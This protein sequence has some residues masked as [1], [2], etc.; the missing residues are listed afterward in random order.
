M[1]LIINLRIDDVE[2]IF[3]VLFALYIVECCWWL[4]GE[5]QR[6]YT[7]PANRWSSLPSEKPLS[8]SWRLTGA[9]PLPGGLSFV[10]EQF[11]CP[12]D[13]HYLLIPKVDSNTGCE[14]YKAHEYESLLPIET[15]N[16]SVIS[17]D[18]LIG[19]F[20]SHALAN[21]VAKT[22]ECLRVAES[23][24]RQEIAAE[25]LADRWSYSNA[26]QRLINWRKR[27][28]MLRYFG[29]VLTV[30]GFIVGPVV[31]ESRGLLPIWLPRGVFISFLFT[32]ISTAI[33]GLWLTAEQSVSAP[34]NL[35][36]RLIPFLSPVSAMRVA[37]TSGRDV[38][39]DFEPL[40]VAF[41]TRD[42][43]GSESVLAA[44]L[45]D[46]VYPAQ[47]LN[48][49]PDNKVDETLQAYR[50]QCKK[51]TSRVIRA[52]DC[53]SEHLLRAPFSENDA[54]AYCPRC[55]RTFREHMINCFYCGVGVQPTKH[56]D[57]ER[58]G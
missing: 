20:S 11:P 26:R 58:V 16:L 31:Y 7:W 57:S 13:E 6:F 10:A 14:F 47:I 24:K 17:G 2:Q 38:L 23:E 4:R 1:L 3:L 42:N 43:Y 39:V 46:A 52:A 51:L 18:I 49:K 8:S 30:L 5:S 56:R 55:R 54:I 41:V 44:W 28:S 50:N 12:F 21:S 36:H 27:T 35:T 25:V 22:L 34:Q 32:W 9:N 53:N 45:R 15:N 33:L 19:E 48:T 29:I 37:E 40:V